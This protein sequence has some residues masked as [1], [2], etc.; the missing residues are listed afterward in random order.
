MPRGP[1]QVLAFSLT[2][3]KILNLGDIFA[4]IDKHQKGT[5]SLQDLKVSHTDA[6]AKPSRVQGL[7]DL[8]HIS[9]NPPVV[10]W[11]V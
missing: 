4:N 10:R 9:G 8:L 1:V 7:L 11:R 3:G 5:I 6:L 2:P